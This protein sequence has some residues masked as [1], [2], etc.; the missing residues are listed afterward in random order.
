MRDEP[1]A[2][3]NDMWPG[4]RCDTGSNFLVGFVW[5]DFQSLHHLFHIGKLRLVEGVGLALITV[6]GPESGFNG[7]NLDLC[8]WKRCAAICILQSANMI[9]VEM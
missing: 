7:W 6:I 1:D 5:R 4:Q 8:V 3:T 2:T 9:T